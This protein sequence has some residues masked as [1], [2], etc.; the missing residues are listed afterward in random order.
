LYADLLGR[1]AF[2]LLLSA[3]RHL[4]HKGTPDGEDKLATRV[5]AVLDCFFRGRPKYAWTVC[6]TENGEAEWAFVRE[7]EAAHTG[8]PTGNS[9]SGVWAGQP[10]APFEFV[11]LLRGGEVRS[12][13][14]CQAS[15]ALLAAAAPGAT[16]MIFAH[17]REDL[18]PGLAN[19]LR[20]LP[21]ASS[22]MAAVGARAAAEDAALEQMCTDLECGA[23]Y[24]T[25][26][27][28]RQ[29]CTVFTTAD[30]R[31]GAA[32]LHG[33]RSAL[34]KREQEASRTARRAEARHEQDVQSRN[35]EEQRGAAAATAAAQSAQG[36]HVRRFGDGWRSVADE[37][38]SI[39]SMG[40]GGPG[41]TG[42][43]NEAMKVAKGGTF[44]FLDGE[45]SIR[46]IDRSFT[47]SKTGSA[48]LKEAYAATGVEAALC[49][50]LQARFAECAA[51]DRDAEVS[52]AASWVSYRPYRV[53]T[54]GRSGASFA[55]PSWHAYA[56]ACAL[57]RADVSAQQAAGV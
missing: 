1:H 32:P 4:G 9:G 8:G 7:L 44:T 56:I 49:S 50:A 52:D 6:D 14:A 16:L 3:E 20:E 47:R 25:A 10:V 54:S 35:A 18:I 26:A 39:L 38:V 45:S 13:A 55:V 36:A 30:G 19:R 29:R 43:T 2:A 31:C 33:K 23:E 57:R 41:C 24:S 40:R 37:F 28:D 5:H 11:V 27:G 53:D 15:E 12:L 42:A 46:T 17:A 34:E 22:L 21:P 51:D 48:I